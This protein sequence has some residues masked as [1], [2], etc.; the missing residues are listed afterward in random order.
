MVLFD[1]DDDGIKGDFTCASKLSCMPRVVSCYV[2]AWEVVLAMF[3][4]VRVGQLFVPYSS[5][6]NSSY[7]MQMVLLKVW[8]NKFVDTSK[9]SHPP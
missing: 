5:I 1:C 2:E 4:H 3:E 9:L 7:D 6:S 8:L